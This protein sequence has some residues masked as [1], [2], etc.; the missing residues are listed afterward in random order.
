MAHYGPSNAEVLVFTFK[1]GLL[2]P[3][4]HDLKLSVTRFSLELG[5]SSVR[6]EFDAG[7][8]K[9]VCAMKDGRDAPGAL[10]GFAPAEIQKNIAASVLSAG[11]HP[12]IRFES[13]WISETEIKGILT[14][15]GRARELRGTRK[16]EPAA[17]AAELWIDQRD[18]GIRPYSAMLGALKVRPQVQVRVRVP[19]KT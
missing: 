15:R 8:L 12:V 10:P 5:E 6:A 17:Y 13:S 14:L 7:S 9:V 19:K 16:D 4:A 11:D 2:S 3:I 1:E 18:F